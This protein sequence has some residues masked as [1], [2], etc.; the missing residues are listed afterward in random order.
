MNVA[1]VCE[2]TTVE[3]ALTGPDK[4]KWK[5]AMDAEYE[6]ITSNNVWDLVE[7]PKDGKVDCKWIFKC[8]L[9]DNGLVEW[10]KA[11][12]V[13]QGYSQRPGVD[14]EDTF[15]PVV[16]FESVRAVIALSVKYNLKLYQMDVTTAFL[17][18]ELKEVVYMKQP[19]GYVK[20]GKERL[21]CKLK[22][23]VYGL[24]QSPHCWNSI[25]N[26]QL[27]KMGFIQTNSDPCLYVASEGEPFVI[28]A[29]VDDI[30]LAGKSDR[31][32]TEVKKELASRFNMK[33]MGELQYFLGVKVIQDLEDG[34]VWIGQPS[35]TESI[36][37]HCGMIDTKAVKTPA[38]PGMK[39]NKATDKSE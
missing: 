34:T 1:D 15:S 32:I 39:L 23:S 26:S 5:N 25:F 28:A 24:K 35:Y 10:Y 14:C 9:G 37:K 7:L 11:R 12:L 6:S 8:K 18:G 2:P 36:L 31:R 33:D 38:N 13:A 30:L 17:N 16:R 21:V 22:R 4:D 3:E 27:K 29:Y 19:E 20:K